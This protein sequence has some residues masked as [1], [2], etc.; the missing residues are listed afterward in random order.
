M[1]PNIENLLKKQRNFFNTQQTKSIDFRINSLKKLKSEIKKR[2][3]DIFNALYNDFRKAEFEAA[4]SETEIVNSELNLILKNLIRWSKP[5]KVR[6]SMLNF[7]SSDYIYKDPYGTVLI[8]APWNYPYQLALM[9][10]IGAI[11][12]GNTV[13]LKPS[14]L[15]PHTSEILQEIIDTIFNEEHVA[16]IQGGVTIAQELL[17]RRWDYIFFTGSV[18]VGRIVAKA[19]AE[20]LTPVTLELGGKSPCIIDETANLKLAARRLVWGKYLNGGQTCIAPD[21]ILISAQVKDK[22]ISYFKDEIKNAYGDDPQKSEDYPRIINNKNFTRLKNMLEGVKIIVGGKTDEIDLYIE[23]TV[24]DE[25]SLDSQ[26]MKDEIFGP[27]LP[28]ISYNN[29]EDIDKL[30]SHF[31][32]PLSF[33]VFSKNKGFI[34]TLLSQYSFGGGTVNDSLVHYGNHRLPFGGVGSSGM[35][36]YHGKQTFETFTHHKSITKRANWMDAPIRYA[37]YKGKIKALKTF[38]KYL[39]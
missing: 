10:L 30:I 12:A 7:P 27:L 2:E 16:L 13:I 6:S 18:A 22:F 26:I 1:K 39:G 25:P 9:P 34:E 11:A 20:Y 23:P 21:Y 35:G 38:F 33:Y 28:I 32:K 29:I 19:A 37:P 17:S 5:K 31:E 3:K 8:I 24:I 4:L 14:E 15:T 36:G